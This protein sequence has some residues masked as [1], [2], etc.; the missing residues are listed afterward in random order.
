MFVEF[1]VDSAA[2]A[3]AAAAAALAQV[4]AGLNPAFPLLM[5]RLEQAKK[6]QENRF[7]ERSPAMHVVAS[8]ARVD[9][10]TVVPKV[11]YL[12]P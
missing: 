11:A 6:F 1:L 2:A 10:A 3:A 8:L 5:L 9:I 12:A 7:R 4:P